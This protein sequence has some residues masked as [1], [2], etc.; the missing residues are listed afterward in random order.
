MALRIP[1]EKMT[2]YYPKGSRD[3]YKVAVC[4][5][6]FFD[7]HAVEFEPA[8]IDAMTIDKKMNSG[9]FYDLQGRKLSAPRKGLNI[10]N[11]KKVLR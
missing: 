3:A 11:G 4:W 1:L 7:D 10:V 2:L 6:E 8:G 9:N 5:K